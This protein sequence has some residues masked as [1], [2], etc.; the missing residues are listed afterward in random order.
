MTDPARS[1]PRAPALADQDNNDN[2]NKVEMADVVVSPNV[3]LAVRDWVRA[4]WAYAGA[5]GIGSHHGGSMDRAFQELA[6]MVLPA[7]ESVYRRTMVTELLA[8][9]S[10]VD[11]DFDPTWAP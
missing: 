6:S 5:V 10:E 4:V 11:P 8:L 1:P 7:F 3:R 9:R 2:T